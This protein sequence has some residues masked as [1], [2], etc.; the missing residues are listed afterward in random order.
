[1]SRSAVV[2]LYTGVVAAAPIHPADEGDAATLSPTLDAA[3]RHL[4]AVGLAPSEDAPCVM[5]ADKGYH[6]REQLKAL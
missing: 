2:D 6:S 5:V 3:A 4:D 1:L